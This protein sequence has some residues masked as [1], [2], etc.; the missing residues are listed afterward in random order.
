MS[1][2]AAADVVEEL[3]QHLEDRYRE[4]VSGGMDEERAYREAAGELEELPAL[5][6]ALERRHPME[7]VE[8]AGE[9]NAGTWVEGVWSDA[10]FAGRTLRKNPV[11]A[12]FAVLTIGLGIGANT[13]VFTLVD[14]LV[15]NP[16]P[17][18]GARDLVSVAGARGKSEA[19]GDET[20]PL[21]YLN[22]RDLGRGN[23]VFASLAGYT[24]PRVVTV[25]MGEKPERMFAELATGS[26]FSTLGVRPA[27]GRFYGAAEDNDAGA[28]AVMNYATWQ[29]RFGGSRE[30]VGRRLRINGVE[31][32]VIGVA[33]RG[34]LGING[35]FGPDIW[36]P[37]GMAERLLPNE[38]GDVLRDRGKA[39]FLGV[40]RLKAGVR[41]AQAQANLE[42]LAGALARQYPEVNQ[43]R[44][45]T[46]RPI[47]E[48]VFGSAQ[49]QPSLITF[50]AAVLLAVTG[51]VL[52]I[53]C[54]NVANLML[55]RAAARG[56]EMA[57]R[58]AIG[59][60]RRRLV[61]QLLTES[62]LIG[63]AGGAAGFGMGIGGLELMWRFRP[64]EVAANL[65]M[66]KLDGAVLLF[67]L[68]VALATGLVFG[69]M[70]ALRATRVDVGESLKE[71]TRTMG[72]GRSRNRAAN[73][74]LAGQVAFSFVLLA[75]AGLFLRSIG[76]AYEIDPGFQTA[77]LAVFLT[78]PGQAGYSE[79]R[80]KGFYKEVRERL[81]AAPGVVSASWASNVP[82][83]ARAVSGLEVE[84]RVKRSASDTV[85]AVENTVDVGY[86]ETAGVALE[87]GREFTEGDG[88]KAAPVAIVNEKMAR[89]YWPGG[90]AVGRRIRLPGET[91][92]REIVGI[93]R[94]ANY[95][96]LAEPP[97]PC[98]YVPLAQK[99]WD[100]MVLYVRSEGDPARVMTAVARQVREAG[101][102]VLVHGE[103]TGRMVV[104]DGLFQARM[105]VG[106]LSTFG[107]L[108]LGLASIGLYGIMAFTVNQRRREMG[109]RM[110][111]GAARGD[112]VGMILWQGMR[113]V[114]V[115]LVL[116][117]P[118]AL[119]VGKLLERALYGVGG[120]DP[121]SLAGAAAV[122]VLVACGACWLP[123]R[124]ASRMDPLAAL[125]EG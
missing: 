58:M 72:R 56:H 75:V 93:A 81:A 89:D 110:A 124:R 17:V 62:V 51:M 82:L 32:T 2:A 80:T 77:H 49:A 92:D 97:Q 59:A 47:R 120:Q 9:T 113:V 40:G 35:V 12:M 107:L 100:A 63:L 76:R 23:A 71:E 52:L 101:P 25:E 96:A 39:E 88:E 85:T 4:L 7:R 29:E 64:A 114:S 43:G 27:A 24:G 79:A 50:A 109:V 42:A 8:A 94:T 78:N 112:L 22:L 118:A 69:T 1:A 99:Y 28:V 44:T 66:P 48:A 11:F 54:S 31:M 95:T 123:A 13:A 91:G 84:G 98:V 60:S 3:A 21:S 87:Q 90:D 14:T 103:R 57:V 122:L 41:R 53:A 125:R 74:L 105:G 18:A 70:P 119:G 5:G 106:L 115:G 45:L 46:A 33:P 116:G 16:L 117:L 26:Y 68:A 38:M 73:A 36:V 104:G 65:I 102:G 86:F 121:A 30:A 34:F 15:L 55:A 111:L 83:W 37:A 108:A 61:R 6:A 20:L 19:K 10:R 67:T